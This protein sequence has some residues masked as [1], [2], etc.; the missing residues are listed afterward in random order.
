MNNTKRSSGAQS[1]TP[2]QKKA[3]IV[4]ACCALALIV[5]IAA[6]CA[7]VSGARGSSLQE[8][9]SGASGGQGTEVNDFQLDLQ[10][11]DAVL[12]EG[13]DAGE[14]YLKETVFVGDSNVVRMS[15]NGLISLDQYVGKEGLG[16]QS[17]P[18]ERCVAFKD[19]QE[20]YTIPEALAKM[21][22][23]RV[24]VMLG[25]NNADGGTNVQDFIQNYK[26]ALN[27]IQNS[28]PYCDII[29]A[30]IP[31]V[32]YD[33]SQY[34]AITMQ[35]IDQMNQAL[36]DFCKESGYKFLN[37]TQVLKDANGY[38]KNE[39]FNQ[40]DIHMKSEGLNAILSYVRT[41]PYET[42][43]RRPDTKNVP[44]RAEMPAVKEE[45]KTFSAKYYV[46][47]GTGGQLKSGDQSSTSSLSFEVQENG[48]VTVTA[49]PNDGYMF[50]R[51][52]DGKTDAERTD[53]NMK[54]N[55]SVTAQFKAK[56]S[57][58]LSETS[59][60]MKQGED[61]SLK[62]TVKGEGKVSDV[63]WSVNGE[64]KA[65]GDSFS[66][67]K[68]EASEKPYKITARV[69]IDGKNY[70]AEATVQVDPAVQEPQNITLEGAVVEWNAKTATLTAKLDP[71]NAS[72][73]F[74]WATGDPACA[75]QPNGASASFTFPE[76]AG[77]GD[78]SYK[79][80]VQ[81]A[82]GKSAEATITVKGK[83]VVKPTLS[84]GVSQNPV[85]VNQEVFF[86]ANVQNGDANQ[87]VWAINGETKTGSAVSFR[88]ADA[89]AYTIT[90]QLGDVVATATIQVNAPPAPEPAPDEGQPEEA[91]HCCR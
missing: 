24:V 63:I 26:A 53:K 87:V 48:S 2:L 3:V 84:V 11:N 20:S 22:P 46:E 82:N 50:V 31:P 32:P 38:G 72:T 14:G 9:S 69:S 81:T 16:V 17:V 51:W 85:E 21:K 75:V 18:S 23:R 44:K 1:L 91:A 12:P 58:T 80:T 88:F 54:G 86:T 34:P 77:A 13:Q 64:K 5:T 62:A 47:Q 19:D 83:P 29:V 15:K 36:A 28:Y 56:P 76:N 61:K 41:H 10:G 60:T 73:T 52:S 6:V 74:T 35:T 40:G 27:S 42:Q 4:L 55:I 67:Q 8:P 45:Q 43:D 70:E 66:L 65:N 78:V 71:A 68:L 59:L 89:G 30:A 39:Y 37:T 49:V 33:H 90:A 79:V 7:I 25:T 57:V